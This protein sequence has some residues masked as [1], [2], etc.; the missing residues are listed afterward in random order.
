MPAPQPVKPTVPQFAKPELPKP[1]SLLEKYSP[2]RLSDIIGQQKPLA[3]LAKWIADFK[4]RKPGVEPGVLITGPPGIGKTTIAHL[5]FA[6]HG[7]RV[8]EMNASEERTRAA[9]V[10]RLLPLMCSNSSKF[11]SGRGTAVVLDEIDGMTGEAGGLGAVVT[12][13]HGDYNKF[14]ADQAKA[15]SAAPPPKPSAAKL[16]QYKLRSVDAAPKP[17]KPKGRRVAGKPV[18]VSHTPVICIANAAYSKKLVP[19]KAVCREIKFSP[20]TLAQQRELIDRV[21]QS[22]G[23][24]C[25]PGV[26]LY[27]AK[28]LGSADMRHILTELGE[29]LRHRQPASRRI[30]DAEALAMSFAQVDT[31][32]ASPFGAATRLL[33]GG[34]SLE[35]S[36]VALSV[37]PGKI[38]N[39]LT[40]NYPDF[41]PCPAQRQSAEQLQR[42]QADIAELMSRQA[43]LYSASDVQGYGQHGQLTATYGTSVLASGPSIPGTLRQNSQNLAPL[44]WHE[45]DISRA[46]QSVRQLPLRL[47]LSV[48]SDELDLLRFRLPTEECWGKD[49]ESKKRVSEVLDFAKRYNLSFANVQ[50]LNNVTELEKGKSNGRKI[51]MA[52]KG[53]NS[54]KTLMELADDVTADEMQALIEEENSEEAIIEQDDP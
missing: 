10:D 36:L 49:A 25:E 37:D 27:I 39:M 26:S 7:Y 6:E 4:A 51:A 40:Q 35:A 48:P 3:D 46:R 13:L 28:R 8:A 15:G 31:D 11:F 24:E 54:L 2:K 22:E 32:S 5:F 42:A 12:M 1:F 50:A 30:T 41:L 33:R 19:L 53:K 17:S 20:P 52:G 43:D 21:L 45:F 29:L 23:Y 44:E 9:V 14:T 47:R 16:A 18:P 34:L 38:P